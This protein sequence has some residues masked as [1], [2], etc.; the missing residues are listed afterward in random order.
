MELNNLEFKD[1]ENLPK[2]EQ[3]KAYE[4]YLTA[5]ADKYKEKNNELK[6]LESE[7]DEYKQNIKTALSK[8]GITEF[9]TATTKL[10][11]VVVDKSFLDPE[12]TLKFLKDNGLQEYVKTKEYFDDAELV[13]A[14]QND[15]LDAAKLAPF[16]VKKE[17]EQLRVSKNK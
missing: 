16:M 17:M 7:V 8:L 11:R 1:I 15:K 10:T 14:I 13:Y 4:M 6:K 2:E 3:V 9:K 12:P 5:Y